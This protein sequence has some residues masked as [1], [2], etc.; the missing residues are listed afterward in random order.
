M[1]VFNNVKHSCLYTSLSILSAIFLKAFFHLWS[2]KIESNRNC[3]TNVPTIRSDLFNKNDLFKTSMV[4][5][6]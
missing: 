4:G 3:I 5:I 1:A 6:N 2:Y